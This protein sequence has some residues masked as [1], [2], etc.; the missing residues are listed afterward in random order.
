MDTQETTI[1]QEIDELVAATSDNVLDLEADAEG[2]WFLIK[3]AKLGPPFNGSETDIMVKFDDDSPDPMILVPDDLE[4]EGNANICPRLLENCTYVKGWR[5]LCPH[6]FQ[7]VSGELL[8]FILCLMAIM[9]N[10]SLCGAMG[11]EG[12]PDLDQDILPDHDIVPD[13]EVQPEE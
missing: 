4:I 8:Q 6:M 2:R 1:T 11:C 9:G 13:S 12:K 3:N 7:D 5:C 10:P